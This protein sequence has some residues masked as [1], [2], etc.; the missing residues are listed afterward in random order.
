MNTLNKI[1]VALFFIVM[2]ASGIAGGVVA[3][4]TNW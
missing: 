1:G 2:V 3:V 4:V